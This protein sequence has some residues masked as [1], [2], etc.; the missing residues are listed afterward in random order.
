MR[1]RYTWWTWDCGKWWDG[2]QSR[3]FDLPTTKDGYNR[4]KKQ[5]AHEDFL[6]EM[7]GKKM[8]HEVKEV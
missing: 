1:I 4:K 6:R 2:K 5:R 8:R 7:S 3:E